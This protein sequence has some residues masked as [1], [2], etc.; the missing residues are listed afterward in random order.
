MIP[1]GHGMSVVPWHPPGAAHGCCGDPIVQQPPSSR[2]QCRAAASAPPTSSLPFGVRRVPCQHLGRAVKRS[3]PPCP[4]ERATV[5]HSDG[6]R[7][8]IDRASSVRLSQSARSSAAACSDKAH[9]YTDCPM[10]SWYHPLDRR[11]KNSTRPTCSMASA[12]TRRHALSP[13]LEAS[14]AASSACGWSR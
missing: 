1:V 7:A 6:A 3:V 5:A 8:A 9:F 14:T 13:R 11:E 2:P 12:C 4:R 10:K